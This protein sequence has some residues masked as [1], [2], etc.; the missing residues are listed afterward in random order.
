MYIVNLCRLLEVCV[1]GLVSVCMTVS[2]HHHQGLVS[3]AGITAV[4]GKGVWDI[5][6]RH[7]MDTHHG[8]WGT[9]RYRCS[10]AVLLVV[11]SLCFCKHTDKLS[12]LTL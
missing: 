5:T 3:L 4:P 10:T 9:L 11:C 6:P 2:I 12:G 7:G 1:H 8:P